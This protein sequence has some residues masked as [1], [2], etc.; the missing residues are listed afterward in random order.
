MSWALK[1]SVPL[2]NASRAV[3]ADQEHAL[4]L[5]KH[6]EK[7]GLVAVV[8]LETGDFELG[9]D[10]HAHAAALRL[11]VAR[12]D[13]EGV[14]A[15]SADDGNAT[16]PLGDQSEPLQLAERDR[17]PVAADADHLGEVFLRQ[18]VDMQPQAGRIT[19]V[20][21]RQRFECAA[22]AYRVAGQY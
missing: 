14:K 21:P 15:A 3:I 22:Q 6:G 2:S 13:D 9:D 5:A 11:V 20:Q 12:A 1:V 17:N 18:S 8:K 7:V 19:A 16:A 10:V 4:E